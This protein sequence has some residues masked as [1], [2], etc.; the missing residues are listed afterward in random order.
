MKLLTE[1]PYRTVHAKDK[2]KQFGSFDGLDNRRDLMGLLHKLGE[3]VSPAEGCQRRREFAAWCVRAAAGASGQSL[4]LSADT[5]GTAGEIYFLLVSLCVF[6]GWL[7]IEEI[8]RRL[9][10]LVRGRE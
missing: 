8:T 9:E 4:Q 3:G 1:V 7:S 2:R 6:P 5:V 10:R